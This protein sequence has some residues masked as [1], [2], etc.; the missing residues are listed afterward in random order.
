MLNKHHI[1]LK[2]L[3][4]FLICLVTTGCWDRVELNK[5]GITS[6]TAVDWVQDHWRVSYQIII[7]QSISSQNVGGGANQ[8]APVMVFSTDGDTIQSAVQRASLEM[9]RTLFFAHN[10][11]TVIGEEAARKGITL[12]IEDYF[13]NAGSRE[14]VSILVS[15]ESGRKILEQ[16]VPLEKIPGAAVQN[17]LLNEDKQDS[18]LNQVMVYQLAMGMTGDS[19]YTVVPEVFIS[20]K[21]QE[22]KSIEMLKNTV[23]NTKLKLGRL[24]VFKKDKMIGWMSARDGYGI[25]WITNRIDQSVLFF[26]CSQENKRFQSAVRI[27]HAKTRLD[28]IQQDGRWVIKAHVHAS[29]QLIENGCGIDGSKPEGLRALEKLIND[30]LAALMQTSL[31]SAKEMKADVFGFAS[32]IHKKYPKAWKQMKEDWDEQFTQTSLETFIQVKLERL[33]MSTKPFEKLMQGK[34]D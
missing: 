25:S 22:S 10:R 1:K 2:C 8:Q 23:F 33:G 31:Q 5:I 34:T 26:P 14:T 30:E 20:G 7:P 29:A 12:V 6:A 9:P 16:I 18:N 11:I 19:G 13:R 32:T 28:P 3:F 15:R 21:G 24:G 17:M 27:L 4:I